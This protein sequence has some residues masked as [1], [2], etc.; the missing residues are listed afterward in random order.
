MDG[1]DALQKV[2][3]A[4]ECALVRNTVWSALGGTERDAASALG[5]DGATWEA[6]LR[7][8]RAH[9]HGHANAY[10]SMVHVGGL[11]TCVHEAQTTQYKAELKSLFA[12]FGAVV[13]VH[14][15]MRQEVVDGCLKHPW[16]VV[17]F[18]STAEARLAVS[19]APKLDKRRLRVA[20]FDHHR[21]PVE[22]AGALRLIV[23]TLENARQNLRV[24]TAVK[25]FLETQS[26]TSAHSQSPRHRAQQ[27]KHTLKAELQIKS[28]LEQER[29]VVAAAELEAKIQA[30]A[31]AEEVCIA[32]A[33]VAATHERQ[34][35]ASSMHSPRVEA[36]KH[37]EVQAKR[38]AELMLAALAQ[39]RDCTFSVRRQLGEAKAALAGAE[40]SYAGARSN[41]SGCNDTIAGSGTELDAAMHKVA[42]LINEERRARM[43][44]IKVE[45]ECLMAE[46]SAAAETRV[47]KEMEAQIAMPGKDAAKQRSKRVKEREAERRRRENSRS[48]HFKA[49]QRREEQALADELTLQ[50]ERGEKEWVAKE[51]ELKAQL[52]HELE[53]LESA[54]GAGG[55]P[56][57][58]KALQR[59][60][61][62]RH[63]EADA[64]HRGCSVQYIWYIDASYLTHIIACIRCL[65][66]VPSRY[67]DARA[68]RASIATE[69]SR[70]AGC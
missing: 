45:N 57:S 6:A 4:A 53:H 52:E 25:R 70:D 17:C 22:A 20:M 28:D 51:A 19:N 59:Q 3:G 39:T 43:D 67:C 58:R 30:A 65:Y 5:L 33:A 60:H 63:R 56:G 21:M 35:H 66:F 23:E 8:H 29:R 32:E 69:E 12:Q 64:A 9:S 27:N 44:L 16:A 2:R 24:H 26:L 31:V 18:H 38:D 37:R 7:A 14:L 61:S 15:C 34:T 47:R 40:S 11:D 55:E 13:T 36:Q 48:A 41:G 54:A 49:W 46:A 1:T 42:A 68:I 62:Q 50:N 10:T